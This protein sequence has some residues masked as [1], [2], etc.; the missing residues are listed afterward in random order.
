MN[1]KPKLLLFAAYALFMAF[2]ILGILVAYTILPKNIEMANGMLGLAAWGLTYGL[3]IRP[4]R[5][6]RDER[7]FGETLL[8]FPRNLN[9]FA[10]GFFWAVVLLWAV[11]HIVAALEYVIR[12][13]GS[14]T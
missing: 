14:G 1:T 7:T 5:H 10:G 8:T 4:K 13:I 11:F 12:L 6:Q 3:Y 2:V 9:F